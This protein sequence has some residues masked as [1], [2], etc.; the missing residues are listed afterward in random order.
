[1]IAVLCN[2]QYSWNEQGLK[3][4][5][6]TRVVQYRWLESGEF[7]A[8]RL[9]VLWSSKGNKVIGSKSGLEANTGMSV[10]TDVDAGCEF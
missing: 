7:I 3:V 1:M 8:W 4:R 2:V 10:L 5:H 9:S 6:L